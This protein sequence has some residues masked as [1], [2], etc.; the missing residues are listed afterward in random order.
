M[1]TTDEEQTSTSNI[2][3]TIE[4]SM[5]I[6]PMSSQ[7]ALLQF[8]I[9]CR[10]VCFLIILTALT[11][12]VA[13]TET[14]SVDATTTAAATTPA[15][16]EISFVYFCFLQPFEFPA[17]TENPY[18]CGNMT[19]LIGYDLGGYDIARQFLGNYSLC[20]AW[21]QSTSNCVAFT[22]GIPSTM[23]YSSECFLKNVI[24]S[25]SANSNLVS[26]HN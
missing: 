24:P 23:S 11:S 10:I 17:I 7:V 3:T 25:A 16:R 13:T 26:A 1:S 19:V 15:T 22:W 4:Q 5:C 9:K 6:S 18:P 8:S 2:M 21:C 14:T 20:C 12:I